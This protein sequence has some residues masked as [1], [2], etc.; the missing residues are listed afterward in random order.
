[1]TKG[2][3][4]SDAARAVRRSTTSHRRRGLDRL[5]VVR[6][7]TPRADQRSHASERVLAA[8]RRLGYAPSAAARGSRTDARHLG[9]HAFD[10]MLERADP[11][12]VTPPRSD[13]RSPLDAASIIPWSQSDDETSPTRARSRSTS[14]RC[15]AASRS[16]AGCSDGRHALQ[17]LRQRRVGRR[18]GGPG[19]R[20]GHLPV[21]GAAGG[22]AA[23]ARDDPD[24]SC[25]ASLP[26]TIRITAFAWTTPEG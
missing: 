21:A 14:T 18:Y 10:L 6:L 3:P 2:Q 17:R 15:S 25:S 5:G 8:A 22:P 1:M 20:T 13:A 12:D 11:R 19:R 9:L 26:A 4:M 7:P 23:D 24:R 16:N